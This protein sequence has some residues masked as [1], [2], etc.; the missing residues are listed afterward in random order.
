MNLKPAVSTSSTRRRRRRLLVGVLSA[1]IVLVALMVL[2]VSLA[3]AVTA[4]FPD[5]PASH[6]YYDAITDLASRGIINGYG[7]GDF[8]PNDAV[9]RQQFAKMIVLTGGYPVSEA[10]ICTF[11]DVEKSD[12]ASFYPD[13]FVAVAAAHAITKGPLP[14]SSPRAQRSAACR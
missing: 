3:L 7:N 12:T 13:N 4:S 5:V 6:P 8:G 2:V 10:D 1:A 14:G 9:T 11:T